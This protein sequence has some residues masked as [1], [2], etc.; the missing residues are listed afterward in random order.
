MNT[1]GVVDPT[2]TQS[3]LDRVYAE[4]LEMPG[5]RLTR[6]QAQRLWGLDESTCAELLDF[7]V[8]VKFLARLPGGSYGRVTKGAVIRPRLP[9]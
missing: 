7:L 9:V 1:N 4:F 5:L 6:P 3:V 2:F 8:D